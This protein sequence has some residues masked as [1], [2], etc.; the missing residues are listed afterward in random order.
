MR[1]AEAVGFGVASADDDDALS[2]SRYQ[3]TG[4][5][6]IPLADPVLLRQGLMA[7]W[8]PFSSRPGT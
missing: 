5:N 7:K 4:R 1:R 8:M 3:L 6:V 2:R